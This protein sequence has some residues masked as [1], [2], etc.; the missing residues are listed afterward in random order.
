MS[1][2]EGDEKK[3]VKSDCIDDFT[4]DFTFFNN[5]N[6]NN[7]NNNNNNNNDNKCKDNKANNGEDNNDQTHTQKTMWVYVTL[8][9]IL[10]LKVKA[11]ARHA[12]SLKQKNLF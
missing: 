7:K 11:R 9:R 10:M 3:V 1:R 12:F 8:H 5:N 4:V 6:N 2:W